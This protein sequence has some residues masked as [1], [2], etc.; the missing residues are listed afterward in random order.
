LFRWNRSSSAPPPSPTAPEE[1]DRLQF[2]SPDAS[3]YGYSLEPPSVTRFKQLGSPTPAGEVY[4]Q[5][6][7][8]PSVAQYRQPTS[9]PMHTGG[10]GPM[11]PPPSISQELA[12]GYSPYNPGSYP[13][14]SISR[15]AQPTS[16][17]MQ[18]GGYEPIQPPAP[19]TPEQYP[20]GPYDQYP[21]SV[22]QQN[23]S[24]SP[25]RAGNSRSEPLS[26]ENLSRHLRSLP[27]ELDATPLQG[28]RRV[29]TFVYSPSAVFHLMS[30]WGLER[31]MEMAR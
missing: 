29:P 9:P 26:S 21:G 10:P 30:P 27:I 23:G 14:P 28:E 19:T 22:P 1:F 25:P 7:E 2:G 8:P 20:P 13:P 11:G 18:R 15:F 12:Y 31:P 24:T 16:P 4:G 3:P 17:P 6:L 5:T